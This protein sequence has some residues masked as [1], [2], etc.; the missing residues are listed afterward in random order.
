VPQRFSSRLIVF[1][2]LPAAALPVSII[3]T[4]GQ[5]AA[6][7]PAGAS[8]PATPRERS[9]RWPLAT[10][11]GD[12]LTVTERVR[13][14]ITYSYRLLGRP[15]CCC[16]P[17]NDSKGQRHD[18]SRGACGR[19]APAGG[20]AADWPDVKIID[21]GNAAAGSEKNTISREENLWGTVKN[22]FYQAMLISRDPSQLIRLSAIE[23][24][25]RNGDCRHSSQPAQLGIE[26]W[27]RESPKLD[28]GQSSTA[29]TRC[30]VDRRTKSS[31]NRQKMR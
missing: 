18:R 3:L 4:S 28:P 9:C 31:F 26:A 13:R 27:R 10:L 17:K 22:R 11:R 12:D 6:R 15:A 8:R 29:A 21:T 24:K 23:V 2:S 19:D 30:N 16:G 14:A 20:R 7:P 25:Q 5:S 1:F